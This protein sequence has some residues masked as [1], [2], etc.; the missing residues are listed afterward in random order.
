MLS[1][2]NLKELKLSEWKRWPRDSKALEGKNWKNW[3]LKNERSGLGTVRLGRKGINY[4]GCPPARTSGRLWRSALS[5][6]KCNSTQTKFTE[7]HCLGKRW[8]G[9]LMPPPWLSPMGGVKRVGVCGLDRAG[10]RL[11]L[12]KW[13]F[14]FVG[15]RRL[16]HFS[17]AGFGVS[18]WLGLANW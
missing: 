9:L 3:N 7:W 10:L 8:A 11:F 17:P 13:H 16:G 4:A 1:L 15:V 12:S 5:L 2:H 6:K 14:G 18:I